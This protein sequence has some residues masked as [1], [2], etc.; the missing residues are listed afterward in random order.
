MLPEHVEQALSAAAASV[1]LNLSV[2]PGDDGELGDLVPD[3]EAAD[4]YEKVEE[5]LGRQRVRM[6]LDALPERE[7]RVV[8]LRFGFKGEPWTLGAICEQLGLTRER[9]RQLESKA[10]A[11]MEHQ[12]AA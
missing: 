2:G 8:E 4:P 12:L 1:S 10:L 7:G 9:V 5:S 6:A 3:L 11:R